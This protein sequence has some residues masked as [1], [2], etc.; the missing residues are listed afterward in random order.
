[1]SNGWL[2]Q[3]D[4]EFAIE[5]NPE[6]DGRMDFGF[7]LNGLGL[8][9]EK[10][11]AGGRS[12]ARVTSKEKRKKEKKKKACWRRVNC[13]SDNMTS[14]RGRRDYLTQYAGGGT[15]CAVAC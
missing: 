10:G 8:V 5:K 1:M 3:V 4:W 7:Y 11:W 6:Q 12:E 15:Y 2:S 13:Y 9:C 14:N